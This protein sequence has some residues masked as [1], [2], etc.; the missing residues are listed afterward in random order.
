MKVSLNSKPPSSRV[1]SR[2][3]ETMRKREKP[4]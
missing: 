3:P 2:I 4:G 1:T